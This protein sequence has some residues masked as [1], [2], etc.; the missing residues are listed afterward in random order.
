MPLPADYRALLRE[1]G[2]SHVGVTVY[3]LRNSSLL[4]QRS[5]IDL[6]REFIADGW[7][8]PLP[9]CV[10]GFDGSG[11]PMYLL[12]DGSAWLPGRSVSAC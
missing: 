8:L 12:P 1:L 4:E 7:P 6:T 5:M 3:G 9:C 10:F 2:G 11:N